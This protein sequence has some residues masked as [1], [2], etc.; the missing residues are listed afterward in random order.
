MMIAV[1]QHL[2]VA[3][4]LAVPSTQQSTLIES[5]RLRGYGDITLEKI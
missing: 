3:R 5:G 2:L 1:N 4:K